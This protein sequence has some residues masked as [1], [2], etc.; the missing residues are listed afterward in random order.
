MLSRET[1]LALKA[2]GWPQ[3]TSAFYWWRADDGEWLCTY[4]ACP[5]V[6][7][8]L[9][10]CNAITHIGLRSFDDSPHW[11]AYT[12]HLIG[13]EEPYWSAKDDDPAEALAGLWLKL[14]KA[15]CER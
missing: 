15:P 3:T 11:E 8:L 9:A 7:E 10:G 4:N 2:A 1:C 5:T 14:K 13:T 6:E 12:I